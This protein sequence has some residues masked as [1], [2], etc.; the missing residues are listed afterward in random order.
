VNQK[1]IPKILELVE[2]GTAFATAGK[3]AGVDKENI[4]MAIVEAI[5]EGVRLINP[6]TVANVRSMPEVLQLEGMLHVLDLEE[7]RRRGKWYS[8]WYCDE[9][10]NDFS[11]MD[12]IM[13]D[14]EVKDI[15]DV[16]RW[17][18]RAA[19][20]KEAEREMRCDGPVLSK[21]F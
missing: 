17:I 6:S 16:L 7:Q 4:E 15:A 2:C 5:A 21:I 8:D 1:M 12:R 13:Q 14:S 9:L 11:I 3:R 19:D 20:Q 18:E 10:T